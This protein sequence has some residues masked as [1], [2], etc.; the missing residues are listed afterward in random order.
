VEQV[1]A[2]PW[3][4]LLTLIAAVLHPM[5]YRTYLKME[6]LLTEKTWEPY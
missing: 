3:F 2:D 4:N 6:G 1:E 5:K